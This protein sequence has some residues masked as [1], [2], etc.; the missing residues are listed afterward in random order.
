MPEGRVH[1]LALSRTEAVE[2]DSEVVNA[3]LRHELD[4]HGV[5]T[6]SGD[7]QLESAVW[8]DR[9]AVAQVHDEGP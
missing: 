7:G 8:A 4:L 1:A 5:I 3:D 6:G 9:L 2:G